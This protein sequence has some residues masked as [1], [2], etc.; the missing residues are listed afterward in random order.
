[1]YKRLK[2]LKYFLWVAALTIEYF[3]K[4]LIIVWWRDLKCEVKPKIIN[5][6]IIRQLSLRNFIFHKRSNQFMYI[7]WVAALS[8][9]ILVRGLWSYNEGICY[10]VPKQVLY[11]WSL[12]QRIPMAVVSFRI[13]EY[14]HLHI[15]V[16]YIET[17]S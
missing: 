10:S 2:Q 5:Y 7:L 15:G 12:L 13:S 11:K 9:N 3:S 17:F 4:G 1:M 8:S 14:F 6:L 16:F